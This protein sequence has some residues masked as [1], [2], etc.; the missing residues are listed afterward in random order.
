MGRIVLIGIMQ[1]FF[2]LANAQ[3][4]E[5][6]NFNYV[7]SVISSQIYFGKSKELIVSTKKAI[8]ANTKYPKL[9][10]Y[11]GYAYLKEK[12]TLKATYSY[13]KALQLNSENKDAMQ[14]WYWA[15]IEM[16]QRE[17]AFYF[18]PNYQF[19]DTSSTVKK[20]NFFA[21]AD[22]SFDFS[23]KNPNDEIT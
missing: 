14:G 4:I 3:M 5:W 10:T 2:E 7:D 17:R 15:N 22:C 19:S 16:N 1:L 11:Q 18:Q 21:V 13:L 12:Q 23:L 6:N 20:N 8:Q 9:Y